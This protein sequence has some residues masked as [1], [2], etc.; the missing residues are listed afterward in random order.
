M[1]FNHL[2]HYCCH[3]FVAAQPIHC[4]ELFCQCR[5][6]VC[7]DNPIHFLSQFINKWCHSDHSY[8]ENPRNKLGS[9]EKVAGGRLVLFLCFCH[10]LLACYS[11]AIPGTCSTGSCCHSCLH[12][13]VGNILAYQKVQVLTVGPSNKH[14]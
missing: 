6:V 8:A 12:V 7:I 5:L 10:L 2:F 13:E 3:C 14:S 11:V 4:F 1:L 9:A